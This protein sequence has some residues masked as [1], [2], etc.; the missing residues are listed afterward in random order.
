MR[1]A[2]DAVP[3]RLGRDVKYEWGVIVRPSASGITWGHSGFFPG[4]VAEARYWPDHRM[5]VALQVNTST[6]GT[7]SRPSGAVL[8]KVAQRLIGAAR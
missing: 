3:S 4:Y 5:A 2:T 7:L 6:G 1:I 8:D